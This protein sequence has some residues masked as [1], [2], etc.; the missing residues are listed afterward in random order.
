MKPGRRPCSTISMG[1]ILSEPRTRPQ[2]SGKSRKMPRKLPAPCLGRGHIQR[3]VEYAFM[4]AD[5]LTTT[6]IAEW[7]YPKRLVGKPRRSL[8]SHHYRY[9]RRRAA[10]V[11]DRVGRSSRGSGRA[12]LWRLRPR[13]SRRWDGPE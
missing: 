3:G 7:A 11:A 13:S 2:I 4:L 9:I 6:Q 12:I 5:E 10:E 1:Q 8:S